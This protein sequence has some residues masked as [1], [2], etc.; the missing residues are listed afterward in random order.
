M[1]KKKIKK[2][3][4]E[5]LCF[6]CEKKVATNETTVQMVE[7]VG[8]TILLSSAKS[9]VFHKLC[10]EDVAGSEYASALHNKENPSVP[11]TRPILVS[12][13]TTSNTTA[14]A[15]QTYACHKARCRER[16]PLGTGGVY[17][18][19]HNCTNPGCD[20]IRYSTRI[21]YCIRCKP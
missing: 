20:R 18:H 15:G 1:A 2:I 14:P 19:K 16:I 17:C 12:T 7:T 13:T 5:Q 9:L 10:F 4:Q 21:P 6:Y 11:V 3:K 8:Y